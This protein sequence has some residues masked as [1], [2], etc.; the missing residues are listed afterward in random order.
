MTTGPK[1]VVDDNSMLQALRERWD[2][3]ETLSPG[4]ERGGEMVKA[5]GSAI[6]Q[7]MKRPAASLW[8]HFAFL[9]VM[10][11]R[12]VPVFNSCAMATATIVP[13]ALYMIFGHFNWWWA[14]IHIAILVAQAAPL[15]LA[16]HVTSH[17]PTWNYKVLEYWIPVLLGP[18]FGQTWYTYYF[19]HIKMHHVEDNA[20]SD[21]SSTLYFQ[22]DSFVGFLYYFFR[23]YFLITYDLPV[24]FIRHTQY[25]KAIRVV[26]GEYMSLV[27]MYLMCQIHFYGALWAFVIP[28]S[29][30]RYGMMSGNWVQHAF[31]DRADPMGGGLKNSITCIET[32]YNLMCFNDGYHASHHLNAKRHWTEHPR[33]LLR[34]RQEYHDANAII[35]KNCDYDL[36]FFYLLTKNYEQIARRWVH[37]GVRDGEREP[38][39]EELVKVL[40]EKTRRFSRQ[41]LEAI[42]GKGGKKEF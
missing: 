40:K 27:F 30:S 29:I 16:L 19:H 4:F 22:R 25:D 13:S 34:R 5:S 31:L 37:V 39:I 9:F 1:R 3:E 28:Y 11:A 2:Y 18:F 14:P 24:Y 10:D 23:F 21:C 36:V 32:P 6:I 8:E 26:L 41:E 20:P 35:L 15:H 38:T 17:R 12:D 42:Y 7:V 33:E